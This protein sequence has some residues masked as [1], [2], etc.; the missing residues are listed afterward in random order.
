MKKETKRYRNFIKTDTAIKK[1]LIKLYKQHRNINKI[2]IKELCE[3]ANIS[4]STFYLHYNDLISI[5]ESVGD[6]FIKSLKTMITE[7]A[8]DEFSDFKPY[9]ASMINLINESNE[10]IKI[11][12]SSEYPLAYI[13]KI[14]DELESVIINSPMISSRFSEV[15]KLAEIRMVVSGMISYTIDL[16]KQQD[17]IDVEEYSDFLNDFLLRWASTLHLE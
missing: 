8:K 4:R 2:T 13:D 11:G 9:L 15:Q 17:K 14:K 10:L 7:M 1:A 6:R 16:I 12:L 3:T 5:F